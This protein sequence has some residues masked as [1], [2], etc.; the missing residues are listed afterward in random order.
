MADNSKYQRDTEDAISAARTAVVFIYDE[1]LPDA[2]TRGIGFKLHDTINS[3][4]SKAMERLDEASDALVE[5]GFQWHSAMDD[6]EALADDLGQLQDRIN[7]TEFNVLA[8]RLLYELRGRMMTDSPE[9][10]VAWM[11]RA[12]ETIMDTPT[13]DDA[14]DAHK[15]LTAA[16]WRN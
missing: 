16:A 9:R 6:V 12:L 7:A 2:V 4:L 13:P 11:E 8:D 10:C 14:D 5:F 1:L 3:E 15:L